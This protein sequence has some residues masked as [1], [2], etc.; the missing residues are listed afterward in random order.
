MRLPG[1]PELLPGRPD[2]VVDLRT[3][4][5]AALVGGTWRYSDATVEDIDFVGVGPDLAPSGAPNRTYDIAPHAEAVDFDDSGWDVLLPRD[6]ERR[7]STGRICFTWYRIG[8]T[9]PKRVGDLDP[10]GATVV[11]EVVV[12]DY[13]EVW[14]DGKLPL[15]LGA[16]GGPVV[17]GFNAPNR[18]VLTSDARPGQRFQIAVFGMNGPISASPRNFVW[19]RSATLD[20]HAASSAAI[21]GAAEPGRLQPVATG[22]AAPTGPVWT[23]D[24][25]LLFNSPEA[26]TVYRWA[27]PGTVTVFRVKS[28]Y[29]GVDIG[30]YAEPGA[31]GLAFDRQGRLTLCEHGN[32]RVLRVEPRGNTTV[33]ADR[34][35]GKRLNSPHGLAYRSDGTLYFTDPPRG[36]PGGADDP[37]RELP[38]SGVYRLRAGEVV[39]LTDELTAPTGIALAPDDR[40]LYVREWVP[41]RSLLMRYPL[42][43]AGGLG[44]DGE[45]FAHLGGAGGRGEN[46][47][48]DVPDGVAVDDA[49]LVYAGAPDGVRVLAPDGR[50][51]GTLPVP[52]TPRGLAWGDDDGR[53]LYIT[54]GSGVYR[55]RCPLPDHAAGPVGEGARR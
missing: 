34:Y 16:S 26:N 22:F 55:S 6:T 40:T 44:G 2:A 38:F 9:V 30:A 10:T 20:F 21:G 48:V 11:F 17:A 5:G 49:G 18:V 37:K 46:E 35:D 28:G 19:I 3:D 36:L 50:L 14:V 1:P 4:E 8:V 27:P 7:L 33:L 51:L 54:A 24:G 31:A 25:A 13:A 29:A 53:T 39:L 45:V 32:R 42:D 15:S 12:D 47:G 23:P 43:D 41:G 52:E